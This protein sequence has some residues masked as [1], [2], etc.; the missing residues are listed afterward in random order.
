MPLPKNIAESQK[1]IVEDFVFT[2]ST[3]NRHE[4]RNLARITGVKIP[5]TNRPEVGKK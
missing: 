1:K 2:N 3:L 5:G 4:R